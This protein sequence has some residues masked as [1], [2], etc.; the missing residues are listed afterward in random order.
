M[1]SEVIGNALMGMLSQLKDQ[2][3]TNWRTIIPVAIT[4]LATPLLVKWLVSHFMQMSLN[5]AQGVVK[6]QTLG[7]LQ[8]A[9]QQLG[10]KSLL[11][12]FDLAMNQKNYDRAAQIVQEAKNAPPGS[13]NQ[14]YAHTFEHVYNMS[15]P[16]IADPIN[17]RADAQR[18]SGLRGAFIEHT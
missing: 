2:F 8:A 11:V 6:G 7:Q 13:V 17:A 9:S 12:E 14:S 16:S 15:N 1:M 18:K 5:N 4:L 3:F 10:G